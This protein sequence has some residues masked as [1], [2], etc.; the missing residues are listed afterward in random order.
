MPTKAKEKTQWGFSLSLTIRMAC[1]GLRPTH[2]PFCTFRVHPREE[3]R[4]SPCRLC[5]IS[6]QMHMTIKNMHKRSDFGISKNLPFLLPPYHKKGCILVRRAKLCSVPINNLR[7]FQGAASS[8]RHCL[9]QIKTKLY[10]RAGDASLTAC[11]R[12][13]KSFNISCY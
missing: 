5:K 12:G 3:Q 10:G 11:W 7:R 8:I 6:V 4:I 1:E 2:K 9:S 13:L